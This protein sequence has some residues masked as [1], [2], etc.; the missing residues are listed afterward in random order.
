MKDTGN[1]KL[2]HFR[3]R[4]VK[5]QCNCKTKHCSTHCMNNKEVS[6]F[7]FDGC[8]YAENIASVLLNKNTQ[9]LNSIR[10]FFLVNFFMGSIMSEYR[11]NIIHVFFVNRTDK[12]HAGY[13]TVSYGIILGIFNGFFYIFTDFFFLLFV[14]YFFNTFRNT[15]VTTKTD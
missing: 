13:I 10:K 2:N 1:T 3:K 12:L 6:F 15:N 7:G 4:E 14:F 11:F 8:I 9:I 5:L